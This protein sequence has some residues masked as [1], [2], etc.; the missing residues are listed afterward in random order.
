MSNH[1]N[2]EEIRN[3]YIY[4]VQKDGKFEFPSQK[5]LATEYD[6]DPAIIGRRCSKEGWVKARENYISERSVKSQQKVIDEM[7]DEIAPF[8]KNLFKK[9]KEILKELDTLII[10]K[11]N[12][13][14]TIANTLKSLKEV[15]KSVLGEGTGKNDST[16]EIDEAI[17]ELRREISEKN[18]L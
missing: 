5:D 16:E 1:I 18:N 11:P 10:L 9:A 15:E 14:F 17:N 3:K 7:S 13:A 12:D 2:W 6:I 8:D 4:G